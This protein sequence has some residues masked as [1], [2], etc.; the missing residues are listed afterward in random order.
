MNH[1][2][3]YTTKPQS[4]YVPLK[5]QKPADQKDENNNISASRRKKLNIITQDMIDEYLNKKDLD[6]N[7]ENDSEVLFL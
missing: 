1:L 6:M 3:T 7:D 4:K 5:T 2:R